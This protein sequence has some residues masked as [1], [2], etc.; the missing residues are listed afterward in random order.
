MPRNTKQAIPYAQQQLVEAITHIKEKGR[1]E[2]VL[3]KLEMVL[4]Q[5]QALVTHDQLTGALNRKTL[6]ERL[7][8]ELQRS[9]RTGH[10]FTVAVIAMDRL[11]EISDRLGADTADQV[12]QMLTT[13]ACLILRAL[14]SFG[15]ISATDFAIVMPTTWSEQSLTVI[16]RL[17]LALQE[18]DWITIAPNYAMSF[19]AGLSVNA[20]SDT[21]EHLL[22]RASLALRQAQQQGVDAVAQLDPDLPSFDHG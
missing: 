6:V 18:R 21:A 14:D 13:E 3:P 12:L 15:R 4:A 10:T 22:E 2:E 16:K 11:Q 5:L 7:D 9:K 17:K 19:C 1:R 8:A 20:T